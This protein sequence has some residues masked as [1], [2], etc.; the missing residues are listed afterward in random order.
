MPAFS[1]SLSH[2]K[3]SLFSVNF[4]KKNRG[5]RKKERTREREREGKKNAKFILH[6]WE[7]PLSRPLSW[8]TQ[9]HWYFDAVI[10]YDSHLVDNKKYF[11]FWLPLSE[12]P[13]DLADPP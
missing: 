5:E 13:R 2:F 9:N 7:T 12:P 11:H 10:T 8:N 4:T 3:S 6:I 1:L